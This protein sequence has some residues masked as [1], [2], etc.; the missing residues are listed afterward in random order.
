MPKGILIPVNGAA[1]GVYF[2]PADYCTQ[3][4]G[5]KG[6]GVPKNVIEVN[7]PKLPDPEKV[8]AAPPPGVLTTP[9][10]APIVSSHLKCPIRRSPVQKR[11]WQAA[12]PATKSKCRTRLPANLYRYLKHYVERLRAESV[13]L[14][15]LM[16]YSPDAD[17][18]VNQGGFGTSPYG[19]SAYLSPTSYGGILAY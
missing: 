2:I 8:A 15:D 1:M 7:P 11:C 5:I 9:A 12:C 3:S 4:L 17:A 13:N 19:L 18:V 16:L 6:Q 14:A 10:A